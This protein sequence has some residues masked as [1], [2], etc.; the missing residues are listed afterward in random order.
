MRGPLIGRVP[1]EPNTSDDIAEAT[2]R[3]TRMSALRE[4]RSSGGSD[5]SG[6]PVEDDR[7]GQ[8][9]EREARKG[10]SRVRPLD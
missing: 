7:R 1:P 10:R 4:P 9:I 3:L 8:F 6:I 5:A 2:P